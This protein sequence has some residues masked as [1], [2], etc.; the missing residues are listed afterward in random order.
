MTLLLKRLFQNVLIPFGRFQP[1]FF[2]VLDD[3]GQTIF[4]KNLNLVYELMLQINIKVK[5]V[6]EVELLNR[7]KIVGDLVIANL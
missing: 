2:T 1:G 7:I 4:K 3:Y 6:Y 5:F